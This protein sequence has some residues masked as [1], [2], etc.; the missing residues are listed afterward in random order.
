[1]M[2]RVV[3]TKQ[4]LHSKTWAKKWARRPACSLSIQEASGLWDSY[5]RN[6]VPVVPSLPTYRTTVP[7]P[8][9]SQIK[10]S[11][12]P[13]YLCTYYTNVLKTERGSEDKHLC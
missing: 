12:D 9:A 13:L 10:R 5:G 7:L 11:F 2:A 1:M 4:I 8:V 3:P 6:K